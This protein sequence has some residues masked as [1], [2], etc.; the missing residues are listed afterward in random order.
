MFIFFLF[1]R[2]SL[3]SHLLTHNPPEVWNFAQHV[4]LHLKEKEILLNILLFHSDKS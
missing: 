3:D 4:V 1:S 2:G